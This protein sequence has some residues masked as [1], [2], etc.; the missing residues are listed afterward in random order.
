MG[1]PIL[2][3]DFLRNR[4]DVKVVITSGYVDEI[5]AQLYG[6]G[7]DKKCI[8]V[9]PKSA[10]SGKLFSIPD[11][12]TSLLSELHRLSALKS[13]T[14]VVFLGGVALGLWRDG[15]LIPWDDDVDML[16]DYQDLVLVRDFLDSRGHTVGRVTETEWA[17]SFR[18]EIRG[19]VE[20]GLKIFDPGKNFWIDSFGS[21]T[22]KWPTQMFSQPKK[23]SVEGQFFNLPNPPERYLSTVYGPS[24]M[25]PQPNFS[26]L[27]YGQ[28]AN[29]EIP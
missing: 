20:F 28:S 5:S 18:L 8:F 24:W 19:I 6:L 9:P 29:L 1:T 4:C 16:V 2:H 3:P 17:G 10:L 11:I 27:D 21:R 26:A 15:S 12:R 22:W 14:P 7:V 25:A 23:I 13:R